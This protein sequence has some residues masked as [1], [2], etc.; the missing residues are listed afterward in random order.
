MI[1]KL[2]DVETL[3]EFDNTQYINALVIENPGFFY[4]VLS[5]IEAQIQGNEG[6]AVLSDNDKV[7]S[8]EKNLEYFVDYVSFSIN[9]KTLINKVNSKL[10]EIALDEENYIKSKEI[11]SDIENYLTRIGLGLT[12][13]IGFNKLSIE[14]LVKSSGTEFSEEYDSL[15]E[16]L[17]DYFE[18]VR[19]Y[20]KDKLFVLVNL[21]SYISAEEL[22]RFVHE[23]MVRGFKALLIDSKDHPL[24]ER[25]K[26]VL[27]DESLCEIC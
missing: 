11:I 24:L 18:L 13:D 7:L 2:P 25:E 27:I 8:I 15:S 12:G 21:R 3:F 5:D 23:I 22:N 16:K 26:R 9:Q 17:L 4:N 6:K 14:N 19:E 10:I 20:D 1:L